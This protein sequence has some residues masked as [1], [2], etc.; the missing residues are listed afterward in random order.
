MDKYFC[1]DC[2]G[3]WHQDKYM[4]CCPGCV[5]HRDAGWTP[6]TLLDT[7]GPMLLV[8]DKAYFPA[9]A[10]EFPPPPRTCPVSVLPQVYHWITQQGFM[11][12]FIKQQSYFLQQYEK[13]GSKEWWDAVDPVVQQFLQP[14]VF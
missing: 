3:L 8:A 11:P 2:L 9:V 12:G 5:A 14:M 7:Y 10:R 4:L 13:Y 6:T 1:K